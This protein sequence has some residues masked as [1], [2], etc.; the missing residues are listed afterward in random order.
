MF[1][2]ISAQMDREMDALM[3]DVAM[4]PRRQRQSYATRRSERRGAGKTSSQ[5]VSKILVRNQDDVLNVA[6]AK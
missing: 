3:S 2:R 5:G 6:N 4:G 1:D